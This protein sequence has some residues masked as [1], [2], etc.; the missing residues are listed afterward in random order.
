[1][2]G[3]ERILRLFLENKGEVV[4]HIQIA[5]IA[6]ITSW[7]R[8]VRE[9]REEGWLIQS[10]NDDPALRPGEYRLTGEPPEDNG[11]VKRKAL[12]AARRVEVFERDES[13]CRICGAGLDDIDPQFPHRKV[14]LHVDHIVPRSQGGGDD[15]KNLRTLCSTCNQGLKNST[16]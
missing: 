8:R 9:L 2:S 10:N 12:S 16:Q 3:K 1:M 11:I 5:N 7:P 14:R 6:K 15:M 4:T 13:T